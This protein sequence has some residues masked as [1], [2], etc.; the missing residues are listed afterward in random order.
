MIARPQA[1]AD[2]R[3]PDR[4]VYE[5]AGRLVGVLC[6]AE[7]PSCHAQL[8]SATLRLAREAASRGETVLLLDGTDGALME[9]AGI[10]YSRTL[11]HF[12]AGACA[13]RD[14]LFVTA[15]E[16]FSATVLHPDNLSEGLGT[17]AALSMSYDWVFAVGPAGLSPAQACLAAG[18]DTCLLGYDTRVDG[19]MRAYWTIDTVRRRNRMWDPVTLAL[20]PTRDATETSQMLREVVRDHLGA[21]APHGGHALDSRLPGDVLGLMRDMTDRTRVA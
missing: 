10:L 18:A 15:N 6:A 9:E 21:P 5:P 19:F 17:M 11:E 16:H 20:G 3:V 8:I 14:A 7:E 4:S 1:M 12:L 13:L 2:L